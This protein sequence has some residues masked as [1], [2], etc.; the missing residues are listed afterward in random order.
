MLRPATATS[1]SSP[2]SARGSFVD[3]GDERL[4]VGD[5]RADTDR[6]GAEFVGEFIESFLAP[7]EHRD[8]A[9]TADDRAAC[10]SA[11]AARST[12][13]EHA[14]AGEVDAYSHGAR[15]RWVGAQRPP[16]A[17]VLTSGRP[18]CADSHPLQTPGKY[19]PGCPAFS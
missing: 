9:A 18:D 8:R 7:G 3:G 16:L 4:V 1:P 17:G 14:P 6:L 11:D 2:P 19:G 15:H 10:R 13:H 12:G 5:I